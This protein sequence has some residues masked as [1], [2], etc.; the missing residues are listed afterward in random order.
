M[1]IIDFG[2]FFPLRS[3][4][5]ETPTCIYPFSLIFSHY[6][7]FQAHIPH[8][9]HRLVKFPFS[10]YLPCNISQMLALK[11]VNTSQI[12]VLSL[13]FRGVPVVR[14]SVRFSGYKPNLTLPYEVE[15]QPTKLDCNI[16]CKHN[17]CPY[18]AGK[19]HGCIVK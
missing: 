4:I 5:A 10:S 14:T 11:N 9:Y 19:Y 13:L 16:S 6:R 8:K 1:Y 7:Y 15:N 12:D 3:V 17:L 2:G 18:L